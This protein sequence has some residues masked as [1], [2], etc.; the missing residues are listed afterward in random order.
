LTNKF[1]IDLFE[2]VLVIWNKELREKCESRVRNNCDG[3]MKSY[4][5][6]EY[7]VQWDLGPI[8]K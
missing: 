6:S 2:N 4:D 1:D 7:Q 3:I 8:E 5:D